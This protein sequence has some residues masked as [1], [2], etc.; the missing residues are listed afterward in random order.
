MVFVIISNLSFDRGCNHVPFGWRKRS[1]K[2]SYNFTS[3][4]SDQVVIAVYYF[5]AVG[6]VF[7]YTKVSKVRQEELEPSAAIVR[8][9][10][11]NWPVFPHIGEQSM[12]RAA[13]ENQSNKPLGECGLRDF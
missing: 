2:S 6:I 9:G 3:F 11:E 10:V 4:S 7:H 13:E 12:K 5:D 1:T 8:V